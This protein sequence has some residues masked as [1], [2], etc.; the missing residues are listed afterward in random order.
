[1]I[2]I[3]F[4]GMWH[5]VWIFRPLHSLTCSFH[6]YA[7]TST[8]KVEGCLSR[9]IRGHGGG[10]A[11]SF[12]LS[13]LMLSQGW[14]HLT[15]PCL[16]LMN[17]HRQ[18]E[19]S[20]CVA[21]GRRA[22]LSGPQSCPIKMEV[23]ALRSLGDFM[24]LTLRIRSHDFS[25]TWLPWIKHLCTQEVEDQGSCLLV[26]FQPLPGRSREAVLRPKR[27]PS[28]GPRLRSLM[29]PLVP[30]SCPSEQG[31]TLWCLPL[32]E[33]SL[34]FSFMS[35]FS[36]RHKQKGCGG[37]WLLSCF[38]SLRKKVWVRIVCWQ[39]LRPLKCCL[40]ILDTHIGQSESLMWLWFLFSLP[41]CLELSP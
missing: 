6:R 41:L 30:K 33:I 8:G 13:H 22:S 11:L 27:R 34:G 31:L 32:K 35:F 4:P 3:E 25:F 23:L 24:G 39:V 36:P 29:V 7:S 15:L 17:A 2:K 19:E 14:S 26:S 21:L 9:A 20:I 12:L 5:P 37:M 38:V 16:L 1:M 18:T 28:P 10:P 40:V